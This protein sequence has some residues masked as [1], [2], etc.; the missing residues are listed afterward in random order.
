MLLQCRAGSLFLIGISWLLLTCPPAY[1]DIYKYVDKHGRVYL[2]DR[3]KNS[4]YKRLVKTWKGWVEHDPSR[5]SSR[6]FKRNM[7]KYSPAVD[8][9]ARAY[10]IPRTLLHAIITA[11]SAYDPAAVSRAGAVGLMQL[12]PATARR[13]G[14]KNRLNP[15]ENIQGGS[16][17]FR[18]LL[19]MFDGDLALALA[20][21]NAGENAVKKYG[22][23]IPPYKETRTYVRRVI[24]YYKQYQ[25]TMS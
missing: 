1:A 15:Y 24:R 25:K 17:Y 22:N 19:I 2:T 14:V 21:Y 6:D 4:G 20:A 16:R 11:E 10:N 8:N 9:V 13:Y 12:M 7:K 18:D 3:P 5:F 23:K